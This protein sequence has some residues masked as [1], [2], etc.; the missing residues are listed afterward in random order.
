MSES[1]EKRRAHLGAEAEGGHAAPANEIPESERDYY[2]ERMYPSFGNL[3][4]RDVA[5]RRAKEMCDQG[6]GVG[7]TGL[8]VYLDFADAIRRIRE[9]G[10]RGEVRQPVRHVPEITG[11]D[12]YAGSDAD[13]SGGPLHDGRAL[14]RLQPDEH[15]SRAVRAGRGEL[16]GSRRQPAGGQRPDAGLADG[17]FIAPTRSATISASS[18]AAARRGEPTSRSATPPPDRGAGHPGAARSRAQRPSTSST[19]SW[20][21]SCGNTAGWP[22]TPRASPKAIQRISALREE[23]WKNVKVVGTGASFNQD[24]EKAGRVA[25]FLELGELIARDALQPERIVRRTFPRGVSDRGRRGK[26]ERRGVL[27]RRGL[28]I[29]RRATAALHKEPLEFETLKLSQRSYK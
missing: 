6:Y 2:L 12:A 22:G 20:A 29:H 13:L 5:S 21:R 9:G 17:Y 15:H 8:A 18:R 11:E 7:A 10:D 28:G 27:V 16:L 24:L 14:G 4:P 1:P 25:D 26:A 3:V 19:G 23:F